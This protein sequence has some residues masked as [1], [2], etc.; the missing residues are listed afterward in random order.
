MQLTTASKPPE[1]N[2]GSPMSYVQKGRQVLANTHMVAGGFTMGSPLN[3][4]YNSPTKPSSTKRVS[5]GYA[6]FGGSTDFTSAQVQNYLQ[7]F[8]PLRNPAGGTRVEQSGGFETS[9]MNM[10]GEHFK[11][12]KNTTNNSRRQSPRHS[13]VPSRDSTHVRVAIKTP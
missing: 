3:Q 7:D 4:S 9:T 8:S 11:T 5:L 13:L 10:T 12:V 6:P 1:R 2:F